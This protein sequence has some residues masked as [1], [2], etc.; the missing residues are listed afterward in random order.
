[1]FL[2]VVHK[3]FCSAWQQRAG[4]SRRSCHR[5]DIFFIFHATQQLCVGFGVMELM[6]RA[7]APYRSNVLYNVLYAAKFTFVF[8]LDVLKRLM[9]YVCF[10]LGN[11]A[12][13][14]KVD[15]RLTLGRNKGRRP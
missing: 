2:L 6:T 13:I 1:M 10:L 3:L 4:V 8:I 15:L 14:P 7:L 5:R 11:A 9:L 12:V